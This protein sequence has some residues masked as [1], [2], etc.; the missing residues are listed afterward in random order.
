[1]RLLENLKLHV[2]LALYFYWTLLP[3]KHRRDWLLSL[4][5]GWS[6][7]AATSELENQGSVSVIGSLFKM[8]GGVG[9]KPE[10]PGK[11]KKSPGLCFRPGSQWG[12]EGPQMGAS[13]SGHVMQ[14]GCCTEGMLWVM[15]KMSSLEIGSF[16]NKEKSEQLWQSI[17]YSLFVSF[18]PPLTNTKTSRGWARNN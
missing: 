15:K 12:E 9:I 1:M 6:W 10:F 16:V 8:P 17:G 5:L 4:R 3:W 14:C 7:K 11:E 13:N 18:S 2:W